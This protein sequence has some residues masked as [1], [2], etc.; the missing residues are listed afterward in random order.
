MNV[1]QYIVDLGPTV[2]LPA[3]IFILSLCLRRGFGPSLVAG[4]TIGVGFVGIGLVI[5]LLTDSLGP[6]AEAMANRFD[7]GLKV[8]D[9]GWPGS[10]PMAWASAMGLLAIPIAIGVNIVMLLGRM[11]RVVNVDIWNIWHMAFTGIIVQIATG[12]F[13]WG[14]VAVGVHAALA[15]KLGDIFGPVT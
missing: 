4:L 11:T 5:G 10:A 14:A 8:V 7:L 12:S 3:I 15:Y 1:L 9:V 6:A 2:M 13:V